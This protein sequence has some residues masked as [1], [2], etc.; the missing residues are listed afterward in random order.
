MSAIRPGAT[1]KSYL[2]VQLA[3]SAA[4]ARN[5]QGKLDNSSLGQSQ[6]VTGCNRL[7]FSNGA[8]KYRSQLR[9]RRIRESSQSVTNCHRLKF[10]DS[11]ANSTIAARQQPVTSC[12]RL[13]TQ[14]FNAH[15]PKAPTV[16]KVIAQGNALGLDTTTD[17]ALKGRHNWA[18]WRISSSFGSFAKANNRTAHQ[19]K[20][21]K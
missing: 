15:P 11:S 4:G 1:I 17:L 12:N 14:I 20:A 5:C 3:S 7:K 9:V 2:I 8:R 18:R 16:R 6:S 13:A 19:T 10:A 21:T